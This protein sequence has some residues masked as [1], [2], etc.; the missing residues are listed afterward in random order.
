MRLSDRRDLGGLVFE[1]FPV[2]HSLT[3]PA[4]GYRISAGGRSLFYVPEV[5]AIRGEAA[6]RGLPATG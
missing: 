4:G 1:A 3:A 2:V 6:R 5:V